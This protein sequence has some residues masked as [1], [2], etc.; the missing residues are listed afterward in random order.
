MRIALAQIAARS[1]DI[2][3][4]TQV[5]ID[6]I[7][8]AAAA[9]VELVVLPE[10]SD[11]GYHMPTI[12]RTASSWDHGPF[13]EVSAAVAAVGV[14]AVVGLSERVGEDI[15]NTA[16]VI[17]PDG[18]LIAKY[19]K[20][21][22]ITAEPVC[23]QNFIRPGDSVTLCTAAGFKVGLMTC[24]DIRFPEFAR[25][26][27]LSGAELLVVPA[28]FPASRITHWEAISTCRAIENQMYLVAVNRV[29]EDEG[30]RFGGCSRLIDPY[31][32]VLA[33]ATGDG[34][35]LLVGEVSRSRLA[36]VRE[37]LH[38]YDDRREDLY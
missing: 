22:L 5:I 6:R 12:V 36:E 26:L 20:T 18:A 9:G 16:A 23:E 7:Q 29:G 31:G 27:A 4:N 35:A 37:S 32:I 1:G 30:L 11:T 24:Y 8:A 28:A 2:T 34:E 21:H 14:T 15:Y 33:S 38:V 19:R 25:R 10:M 13:P 17:G 3:G